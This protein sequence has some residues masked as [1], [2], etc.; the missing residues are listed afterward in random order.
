MAMVQG[1]GW[2]TDQQFS[3]RAILPRCR[4]LRPRAVILPSRRYIAAATRKGSQRS[5]KLFFW[6]L[7]DR[8]APAPA[9]ARERLRIVASRLHVN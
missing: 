3:L 6:L 5:K 4:H 9:L 7:R 1:N 2:A 8:H